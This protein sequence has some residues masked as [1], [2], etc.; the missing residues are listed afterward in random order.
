[1]PANLLRRFLSLLLLPGFWMVCSPIPAGA[2]R[3]PQTIDNAN[4]WRLPG[5]VSPR[6]RPELD[7]GAVEGST[8]MEGMKL[9]FQ[10]TP[11]Q[12]KSLDTLLRQ[13]LDPSSASYHKWLTPEQ[14]AERFGVSPGDISRLQTGCASRASHR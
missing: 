1:M 11:E 8:A 3:I 4:L 13:Q 9:V 10:L 12:Q 2:E 5:S 7:R 6:A 14:Y